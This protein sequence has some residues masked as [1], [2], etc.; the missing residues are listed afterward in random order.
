MH[1]SSDALKFHLRQAS[2]E[3]N[4]IL[5][6]IVAMSGALRNTRSVYH[7]SIAIPITMG[8]PSKDNCLPGNKNYLV[9][10]IVNRPSALIFR[11]VRHE[12]IV[13]GRRGL[14]FNDDFCQSI[15]QIEN[16]VF[17]CFLLQPFKSLQAGIVKSDSGW[18]WHVNVGVKMWQVGSNKRFD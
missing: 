5:C 16:D 18:T 9:V 10:E 12:I 4:C 2:S 3:A 13:N 14:L 6:L 7:P 11:E 8:N 17:Q 1:L 15:V